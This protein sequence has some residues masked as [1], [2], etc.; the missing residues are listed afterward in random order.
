M[1]NGLLE[2]RGQVLI[3]PEKRDRF[4][5]GYQP[6]RIPSIQ[7]TFRRAGFRDGDQINMVDE[8]ASKGSHDW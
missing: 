5:L 4:G 3:I 2:G 8:E 6:N 7:E 1:D